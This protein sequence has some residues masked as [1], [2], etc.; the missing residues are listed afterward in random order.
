MKPQGKPKHGPTNS[1]FKKL[2]SPILAS[3]YK[4]LLPIGPPSSWFLRALIGI[5]HIIMCKYITIE[6]SALRFYG[7]EHFAL[8]AV[9]MEP[10]IGSA[11][12]NTARSF[13]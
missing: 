7:T 5:R 12:G 8:K 6:N 3:I 9:H 10:R 11:K 4:Y 13:P 2:E 1:D